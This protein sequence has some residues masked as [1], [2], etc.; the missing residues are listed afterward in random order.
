MV[1]ER[2][3]GKIVVSRGETKRGFWLALTTTDVK[4]IRA[5][6]RTLKNA[7][8]PIVGN[9]A[10]QDVAAA[11]ASQTAAAEASGTATPAS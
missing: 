11:P 8:L 4:V 1:Q 2:R 9:K 6:E 10:E 5:V 7:G 3:P